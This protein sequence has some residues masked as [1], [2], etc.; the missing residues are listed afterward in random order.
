M[1]TSG[2]HPRP[3]RNWIGIIGL[4]IAVPGAIV[5]IIT[6]TGGG[7]ASNTTPGH[8]TRS[9]GV[10]TNLTAPLISGRIKVG[11]TVSCSPGSW[12]GSPTSYAYQWG[13]G[14]SAIEGATDKT[15]RISSGDAGQ[16]L[17]CTVTAQNAGGQSTPATSTAVTVPTA[18]PPAPTIRSHGSLTLTYLYGADLDSRDRGWD[19][20]SYD[21][22][23]EIGKLDVQLSNDGLQTSDVASSDL[24]PVSRRPSYH[25]C[26]T[27]TAYSRSP[28]AASAGQGV[29][30]R[31]TDHR[32]ASLLIT[33]IHGNSNSPESM[34]VT[35]R[36]TVWDP[37]FQ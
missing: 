7:K 33:A 17:A 29:C 28:I 32:Y 34:S 22:S 3:T 14:G 4:A 20:S 13:E 2:G 16:S 15:F 11:G 36:V 5:A 35:M 24:A 9:T 27:T 6:L 19:V 12:A 37:P 1:G 26:S 25:D 18:T 30:V 10:P 31:T 8:P 21:A 23:P